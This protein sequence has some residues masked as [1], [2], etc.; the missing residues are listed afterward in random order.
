MPGVPGVPGVPPPDPLHDCP[1]SRKF[2]G[3]L[4]EPGDEPLKPNAALAPV[5]S[6]GPQFGP[7][8]VTCAPLC[9]VVAS[10]VDVTRCPSG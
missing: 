8:A 9:V 6:E 5:P 2:V 4:L 3:L 7:V 10:H 1:L